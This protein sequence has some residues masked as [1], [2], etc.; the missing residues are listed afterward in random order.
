MSLF[1]KQTDEYTI[2]TEVA[3][4]M[5]QNVF[6]SVGQKPNTIPFD[7]LL[8]RQK[9][10]TGNLRIARAVAVAALIFTF[11]MPFVF[12]KSYMDHTKPQIIQDYK[13][14]GMLWIQLNDIDSGVDFSTIYAKTEDGTILLPAKIDAKAQKVAFEIKEK[15]LN[16]YISDYSGNVTHAVYTAK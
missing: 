13:E 7:K 9:A 11:I 10:K 16:I 12:R 15:T 3:D 2:D 14:E 6:K 5:L 8:L 4:Q 1:K